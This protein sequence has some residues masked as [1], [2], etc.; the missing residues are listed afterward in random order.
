M[1]RLQQYSLVDTLRDLH[2][3]RPGNRRQGSQRS[4]LL[5]SS[6]GYDGVQ[7]VY[8]RISYGESKGDKSVED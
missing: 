4:L 1:H 8:R 6:L 5:M 2:R 7:F 3:S